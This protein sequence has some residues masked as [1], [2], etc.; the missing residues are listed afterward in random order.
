MAVG[1]DASDAHFGG[2]EENL[3]KFLVEEQRGFPS[4]VARLFTLC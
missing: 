1:D 4:R 3:D 2:T